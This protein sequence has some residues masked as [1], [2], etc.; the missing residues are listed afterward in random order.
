LLFAVIKE[1]C[2]TGQGVGSKEIKEKYNFGFSP[3]TIRNEFVNLRDKG[4]LFQPFTNSSSQPTDKAYR[5]FINQ[6]IDGLKITNKQHKD[7]KQRIFQLEEQ[8][9]NL[10]KEVSRLLASEAGGVGF[11]VDKEQESYSGITNLLSSET[12][13]KVT[14][15]LDFLD[16]LDS[17]KKL[18]LQDSSPSLELQLAEVDKSDLD[19]EAKSR[20]KKSI[21]TIFGGENPLVP[22]GKG[23][24]MVATDIYVNNK[25]SVV[26]IIAP[27]HLL[28]KQENLEL[29]EALAEVLSKNK[30]PE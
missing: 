23:F 10:N 5:I 17:H 21:R 9:S 30:S 29:M 8:Q 18:L 16:N 6:L 13:G 14:D 20:M 15:I 11:F 26:G 25:K 24:A 1:Y 7:L 12:D 27:T 2:D 3:A 4:Y 22:L 19:P 28:A